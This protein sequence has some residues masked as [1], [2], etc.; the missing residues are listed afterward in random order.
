MFAIRERRVGHERLAFVA[1]RFDASLPR[2]DLGDPV[3]GD[4]AYRVC[5]YDADRRAVGRLVVDR[6][7][8]TCGSKGKPCWKATEGDT[9]VYRDPAAAADGVRRLVATAGDVGRGSISI[10]AGNKPRAGQASLPTG[11]ANA[12]EANAAATVQVVTSDASCVSVVLER[13]K[14]ADGEIFMAKRRRSR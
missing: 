11:L 5:V 9:Y 3:T 8:D 12:L 2:G 10:K 7:G 13:V 1:R 14:R 6:A 4:T